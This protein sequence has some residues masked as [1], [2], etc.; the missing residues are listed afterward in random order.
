[1]PV[2]SCLSGRV[3]VLA[4]PLCPPLG[5]SRQPPPGVGAGSPRLRL[6]PQ[7]L[8]AQAF[9]VLLQP[10]ACVLK[11]AAQ[12]PAS[13]GTAGQGRP[14]GRTG[15]RSGGRRA[16][17][18]PA[19][20]DGTATQLCGSRLP[21]LIPLIPRSPSGGAWPQWAPCWHRAALSPAWLGAGTRYLSLMTGGGREDQVCP[22]AGREKILAQKLP[23]TGGGTGGGASTCGGP[24]LAGVT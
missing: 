22:V 21:V 7:A 1:M 10:L 19:V 18:Q 2:G 6:S 13:P 15:P 24:W 16:P 12:A 3:Q 8:S 11:A 5:P 20:Q 4:L 14:R 23:W 17:P 9:A